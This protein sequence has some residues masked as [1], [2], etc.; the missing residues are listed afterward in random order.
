MTPQALHS[1][2]ADLK[3]SFFYENLP[4]QVKMAILSRR[5]I[6]LAKLLYDQVKHL[7]QINLRHNIQFMSSQQHAYQ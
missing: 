3:S 4:V 5:S 2:F 7:T 6:L 1:G